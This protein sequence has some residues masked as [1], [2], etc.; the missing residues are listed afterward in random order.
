MSSNRLAVVVLLSVAGGALAD[1]HRNSRSSDSA[2]QG[3]WRPRSRAWRST[4]PSAV[5]RRRHVEGRTGFPVDSSTAEKLCGV[6]IGQFKC[7]RSIG[8]FRNARAGIGQDREGI[9]GELLRKT[10]VL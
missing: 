8:K 10:M 3:V 9:P 1:N 5:P 6:V 4:Q 7:E 2:R